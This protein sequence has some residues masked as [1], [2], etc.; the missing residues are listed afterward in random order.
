MGSVVVTGG[1]G[2][3]GAALVRLLRAEGHRAV[4]IDLVPNAQ[5]DLSIIADLTEE[6]AV[7]GAFERIGPLAGLACIAGIN[8]PKTRVEAL[9]WA[10]W[11]R[12]MTVNVA[13]TML[14]MKHASAQL[15]NGAGIVLMGS[16]SAHIGTDGYVAYHTSKG[17]VLGLMRAA[18]GEFAPRGIRVNAVSPGW[19]DTS[20][21]DRALLALPDGPA[22]RAKAGEAHLLGRIAQP[23]EVAE[24]ILFLLSP[25]ASFITGTEL[26]V[27]GGF[28]RKK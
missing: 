12:V 8:A 11:S 16:V 1:A 9:S 6:A 27:D 14:A 25:D 24:A 19:V 5:A 10:D 7:A 21:T 22:I 3:M 4:S 28:M 20:F 17:A 13:G 23:E 2:D 18:S 26:V 15:Q